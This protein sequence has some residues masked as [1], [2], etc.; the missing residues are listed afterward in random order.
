MTQPEFGHYAPSPWVR[1]L[2]A[3]S[4]NTVLGRGASRRAISKMVQK[5]HPGPLDAR[6]WGQNARVHIGAN[7]NEIKAL[8][9]PSSFNRAELDAM[10]AAL[11]KTGGV[12]VDIGANVGMVSLAARAHLNSGTILSIEPQPAMFERLS[13]TLLEAGA[14]PGVQ[15]IL[16]NVAVGPQRGRAELAVPEQP[17]MASFALADTS[18]ARVE[19]DVLPLTEICEEAGL[20]RIDVIKIDIEGYEDR[21]IL[22]FFETA[23][24][25]L[26]PGLVIMEHCH[27]GRWERDAEAAIR[28][29]GYDEIY[30]DRGNVCLKRRLP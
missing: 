3:L 14:D 6:I 25:A 19:V 5:A 18:A 10:R 26:W 1:F 2:L 27:A 13:F 15:H 12:L 30:R 20:T 11:P 4:Q 7:N 8:L 28:A 21:A 17:G 24:D 9:S 22:P 16:R 29:R 23:Q